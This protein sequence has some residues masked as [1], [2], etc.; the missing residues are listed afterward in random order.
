M[1]QVLEQ[2]KQ[3]IIETFGL[4]DMP[5]EKQ[6]D[7]IA[8]IGEVFLK[9]LFLATIDKL[10]TGGTREYEELLAKDASAEEMEAFFEEKIPG[11]P[12]FV[13]GVVAD[14]KKDMDKHLGTV[15]V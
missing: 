9:R 3:E 5:V 12:V 11:Y 6:D 2:H 14:F 15:N 8:K 10:G 13:R 4:E 7:L 1:N